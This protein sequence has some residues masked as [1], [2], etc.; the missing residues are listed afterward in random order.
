MA[1]ELLPL[2]YPRDALEPHMSAE[3]LDY[4]YGKHHHAYV[5]HLNRLIEG[6]AFEQSDLETIVHHATGALFNQA[7]QVWNHSFFWNSLSPRGGG[8][9]QGRL[10]EAITRSFGSFEGFKE[11]FHRAAMGHFGSGWIWLVQRLDGA[12]AIIATTHAA[13]PLAS[14]ERPLLALDVWEHAYYIDH[15]NAR[16]S[17]LDAFWALAHWGFAED[18]LA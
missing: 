8:V 1:I 4:H 2:P 9:P 11:A 14:P 3:T 12:L 10:A 7:A 16:A 5:M 13:T 18:N 17:Y 6:T 15:R